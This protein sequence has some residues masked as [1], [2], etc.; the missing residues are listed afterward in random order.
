MTR[1]KTSMPH[2]IIWMEIMPT[3]IITNVT[4]SSLLDIKWI[5]KLPMPSY[6]SL[7]LMSPKKLTNVSISSPFLFFLFPKLWVTMLQSE[8]DT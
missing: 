4:F 3:P 1:S 6:S 8:Q 5:W 7:G 2:D